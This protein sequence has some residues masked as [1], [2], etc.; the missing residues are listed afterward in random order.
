MKFLPFF[1]ITFIFISCHNECDDIIGSIYSFQIPATL[2]PA[3]EIYSVGDTI[4]I[5][6]RF[7]DQV[8]DKA[9]NKTYSL[10]DFN[11]YPIARAKRLDTIKPDNS[12]E[13][14]FLVSPEFNFNP[15]TFSDGVTELNGQYNYQ[16]DE[17]YL[18]YRIIL[19][20][21]GLFLISLATGPSFQDSR[22][23][24]TDRCPRKQLGSETQLNDG[25]D[26]N[27]DLLLESV[28]EASDAL[29]ADPE[30][31]FHKFGMYCFY[32]E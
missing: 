9:T 15:F 13:F 32:V 6:S 21:T 29:H 5:S 18:E 30:N 12:A 20:E 8:F 26:N 31:R 19:K 16:G 22:Q 24:F 25:S 28:L 7:S 10:I 11:F 27:V 17:Y 23:E 3:K 4:T 2:S 1:F 14:E